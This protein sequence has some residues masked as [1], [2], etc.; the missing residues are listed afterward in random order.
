ALNWWVPALAAKRSKAWDRS[1]V[2][3]AIS[4]EGQS[5]DG[6]TR[7][8]HQ[9]E[10]EH[11]QMLDEFLKFHAPILSQ[12]SSLP[13]LFLE[14]R[15]TSQRPTA[16]FSRGVAGLLSIRYDMKVPQ[17]GKRE[18]AQFR[19]ELRDAV[20]RVAGRQG[21]G[22]PRVERKAQVLLVRRR[23]DQP[24]CITNLGLLERSLQRH[25]RAISRGMHMETLSLLEQF[26]LVSKTD[27]LVGAHGAGLS[28]LVA[29]PPGSAVVEAMPA[30]LPGY[31]I[32]IESWDQSRNLRDSIYGG[33]AHLAG[34]H[35]ICMKG[36][37]SDSY[38]FTVTET[39]DN[40]REHPIELPLG[41]ALRRISEAVTMA[42]ASR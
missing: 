19:A 8:E 17:A 13:P 9:T 36:N 14:T 35:H 2:Q 18:V 11:G 39:V 12:L 29:M 15:S 33:L 21:E 34:Q 26:S 7:W 38:A 25:P 41:A 4:F 31:I 37:Y 32:C 40:F 23:T 30:K 3:I 1:R 5:V 10:E 20:P 42:L 28:W 16:C 24:R 22:G 6:R 27:V